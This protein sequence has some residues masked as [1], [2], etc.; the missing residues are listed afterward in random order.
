MQDERFMFE[1][2]KIVGA[3]AGRMVPRGFASPENPITDIHPP[4]MTAIGV[5]RGYDAT[6]GGEGGQTAAKSSSA[7]VLSSSSNRAKV[8]GQEA[9]L[10]K[11]S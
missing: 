5:I 2:R 6:R 4:A 9:T 1:P 11:R 10:P 7:G 3:H 8:H